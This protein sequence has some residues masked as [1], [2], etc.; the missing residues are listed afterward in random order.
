MVVA[1]DGPVYA[2]AV[3]ADGKIILGGD[4]TTVAGEAARTSSD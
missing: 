3:Q 1:I 4:F 2:T